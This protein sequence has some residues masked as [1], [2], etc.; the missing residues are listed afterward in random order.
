MDPLLIRSCLWLQLTPR[1]ILKLLEKEDI[2]V[3]IETTIL[4][5][6]M[7]KAT[8]SQLPSSHIKVTKFSVFAIHAPP[9][10]V[11]ERRYFPNAPWG[12]VDMENQRVIQ[13][14]RW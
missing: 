2:A 5:S 4:C 13:I 10:V 9:T 7:I 1:G 8:E 6:A 14:T 3:H 12:K 11:S